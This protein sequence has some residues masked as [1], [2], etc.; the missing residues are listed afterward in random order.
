MDF[1]ESKCSLI[2]NY[3]KE[4]K[5]DVVL[6]VMLPSFGMKGELD[7]L[8]KSDLKSLL[9]WDLEDDIGKTL[10]NLLYVNFN[11]YSL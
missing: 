11:T 2:H 5:M 4:K 10:D 7:V 6:S 9:N 8:S 3:F 1:N